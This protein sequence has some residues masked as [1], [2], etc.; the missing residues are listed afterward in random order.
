MIRVDWNITMQT[1]PFLVEA[2]RHGALVSTADAR[3][4]TGADLETLG[5]R[6]T[7]GKA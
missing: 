7:R 3:A 6:L 4:V 1:E 2:E 5:E